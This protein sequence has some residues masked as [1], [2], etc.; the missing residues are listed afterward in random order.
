[1]IIVSEVCCVERVWVRED[2]GTRDGEEKSGL[3]ALDG[4]ERGR[5]QEEGNLLGGTWGRLL[6]V[7]EKKPKIK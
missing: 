2:G 5:L 4:S 1:M 7:S 3:Y 6:K